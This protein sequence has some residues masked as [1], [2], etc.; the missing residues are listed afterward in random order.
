[1]N[2]LRTCCFLLALILPAVDIGGSWTGRLDGSSFSG[3]VD[4]SFTASDAIWTGDA[5]FRSGPNEVRSPLTDIAC[6]GTA[7]TFS[8][9]IE[10]A[11]VRF[12][13]QLAGDVLTGRFRVI[14]GGRTL[15]EGS[16]SAARGGATV[17][18]TVS[19]EARLQPGEARALVTAA[20]D[21]LRGRYVDATK[22]E[23]LAAAIESRLSA[24][25]YEG[26]EDGRVL[27]DLVGRDLFEVAGD[28]HLKLSFSANPLPPE[29]PDLPESPADREALSAALRDGNYGFR[30]VEIL[31]GNVGLLEM[32]RFDRAD[33]AGEAASLAMGFLQNCDALIIDLRTCGGGDP[34]MVAC[35]A[36]WLFDG[37]AT[38]VAEMYRREDDR[39]VQWWTSPW[40]P[41]RRLARVPVRILTA[42]RT[43]SAAEALAFHLQS[44]GRA[45]VVGERTGGGAHPSRRLRLADRF[46]ITL[47]TSRAYD[48]ET[49]ADWEGVGVRP[50]VE[51]PAEDALRVA[52]LGLL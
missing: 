40:V 1:M 4:L 37:P 17:P 15:D 28:G 34:A 7:L 24:G 18:V 12:E 19:L 14:E 47:P 11:A 35:L 44:L 50:D 48:P 9:T 22:G 38:L 6:D 13:G 45:Q 52:H 23:T 25:A 49:K 32:S 26:V 33:L 27:A 8:A 46:T 36:S 39:T 31:P 21:V 3:T 20:A 5:V 10:G 29:A 30:K 51:A 2:I 42:S 43:Y 41:H 16:W